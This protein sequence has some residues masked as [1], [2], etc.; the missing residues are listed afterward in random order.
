M[1]VRNLRSGTFSGTY[2]EI[3]NVGEDLVVEREV[4]AGDNIN[5]SL[6]LDVPVLET[7]SF[8]LGEEVSLGELSAPVCFSSLLQVAVD[9]HAGKTEDGAARQLISRSYTEDL[10]LGKRTIEP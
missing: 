4:I 5:A 1:S 3:L 8:C 7:K 10:C 9:A 6:L 2:S